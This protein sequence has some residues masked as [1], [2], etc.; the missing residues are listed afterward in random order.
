MYKKVIIMILSATFITSCC[1]VCTSTPPPLRP[2]P[3][4]DS[5]QNQPTLPPVKVFNE[6]GK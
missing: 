2:M 3:I 5:S 1:D 6:K 4:I